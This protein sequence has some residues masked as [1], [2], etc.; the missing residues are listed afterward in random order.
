MRVLISVD[1]EGIAGVATREQTSALGRG[2][3]A[4]CRLM[5][6]EA[7]AAVR[8]AF[9]GGAT[10]VIVNDSHGQMDNLVAAD[11]DDR[12]RFV[13]GR[14]KALSMMETVETGCD[15]ALFVGYHAGPD[16]IDGV[17]PHTYSGG[18]FSD[19]RLNG[20]S[21]GEV[22]LNALIAA[23]FGVPVGLVTGDEQVCRT[24]EATLPGVVTVAVKRGLGATA[25]VS[26][27]PSAACAAVEDGARRAV[28]GAASLV[29]VDV[30]DKLVIEVEVRPNG[31]VELA[32][33][34]PGTERVSARVVRRAVADPREMQ[35]VLLCWEALITAY[36]KP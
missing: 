34:V 19:V 23:Q 13:V 26:M 25:A 29:P 15:L 17:L 3:D 5:T 36:A 9:D 27:T 21:V 1:M 11:L 28:E 18:A 4:A 35:D 10:S 8:G 32:R 30:P 7:N 14:P 31:A 6:A 12:V 2:Y 16:S 20:R 24:A 33:L 22:D